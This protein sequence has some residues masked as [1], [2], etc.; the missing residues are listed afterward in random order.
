MKALDRRK[1]LE[2]LFFTA[3][4]TAILTACAGGGSAYGGS[5]NPT[6]QGGQKKI[7]DGDCG[8]GAVTT[9]T[10][11]THAH[12]TL[13]FTPQQLASAGVGTYTL[14]SGSHVHTFDF[15]AAD[16]AALEAKQTVT[17][18]DNEG[19]GHVITITC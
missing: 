14:L 1:F 9:Y 8:T 12:T 3:A 5:N 19:H 16:F 10:N 15:T 6:N 2:G 17:K 13:Q 11:V 4:G 18:I 7:S